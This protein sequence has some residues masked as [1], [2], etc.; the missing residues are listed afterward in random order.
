MFKKTSSDSGGTRNELKK[1]SVG[2]WQG[3]F[4]SLAQVG[5]AADIAILLIGTFRGHFLI[6]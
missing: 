5:P 6:S 4:Y 1:G 2:T 3:A